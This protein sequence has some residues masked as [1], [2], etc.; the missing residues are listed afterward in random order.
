MGAGIEKS[1]VVNRPVPGGDG[2][3]NKSQKHKGE[4]KV[5]APELS[6]EAMLLEKLKDKLMTQ[7]PAV[8]NDF[9]KCLAL[10]VQV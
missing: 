6:K 3:G 1:K 5:E 10:Y 2:S 7:S 9:L 4:K 8:Y